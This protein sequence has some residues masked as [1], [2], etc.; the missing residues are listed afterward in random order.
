MSW[1]FP[2]YWSLLCGESAGHRRIPLTKG[3][4]MWSLDDLFDVSLDKLSN[5]RDG[6]IRHQD[7]Q[8]DD[9]VTWN[10]ET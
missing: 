2:H 1:H 9:R 4:Q 3:Q 7:A 8:R 6:G 10:I 5:K